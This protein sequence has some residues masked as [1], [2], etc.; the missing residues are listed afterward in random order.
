MKH[1]TRWLAMTILLLMSFNLYATNVYYIANN[2][3]DANDGLSQETA[4][5]T[6]GRVKQEIFPDG[7]KILLKRG[8]TF[9]G[10]MSL[11]KQPQNISFDAY[12]DGAAPLLKGSVVITGWQKTTHPSLDGS[13]V[14]EADVTP[15]IT[16]NSDGTYDPI[17]YLFANDSM[18]TIA[19]YPN[20]DSPKDKNWLTIDKGTTKLG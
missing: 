12:G 19:R 18:M 9:R 11:H 3:N 1:L 16:P 6:L 2:G 20:V 17:Q 4:W 15:F 10:E 5:Q 14:Y 7:A 13:K 8:E